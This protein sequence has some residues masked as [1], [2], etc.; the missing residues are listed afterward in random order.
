MVTTGQCPVS[1]HLL[2]EIFPDCSRLLLLFP[3]K[4]KAIPHGF[5]WNVILKR[6][7]TC[8]FRQHQS[9]LKTESVFCTSSTGLGMGSVPSVACWLLDGPIPT[10]KREATSWLRPRVGSRWDG[11][12]SAALKGLSL[13][14]NWVCSMLWPQWQFPHRTLLKLSVG[15]NICE[16]SDTTLWRG[17]K[18]RH[19]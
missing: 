17:I 18:R 4:T 9:S 19:V 11:G 14:P 12:L 8:L 7:A 10:S 6:C 5:I 15:G 16:G 1:F 2:P 3:I 13:M